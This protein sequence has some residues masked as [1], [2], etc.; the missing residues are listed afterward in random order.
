[1]KFKEKEIVIQIVVTQ[2]CMYIVF[3]WYKM[4]NFYFFVTLVFMLKKLIEEKFE[5]YISDT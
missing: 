3:N 2:I 1:M 5:L 4:G